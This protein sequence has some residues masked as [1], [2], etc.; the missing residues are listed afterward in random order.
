MKKKRRNKIKSIINIS[1]KTNKQLLFYTKYFIKYLFC[2]FHGSITTLSQESIHPIKRTD[3]KDEQ[4]NKEQKESKLDVVL[5]EQTVCQ[6]HVLVVSVELAR[7]VNQHELCHM[8]HHQEQGSEKDH[9]L[10]VADI[11][12]F[13]TGSSIACHFYIL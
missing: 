11:F 4:E 1:R 5:F 13:S 7:E 3:N 10:H 8:D 2:L 9:K 12:Q 6:G